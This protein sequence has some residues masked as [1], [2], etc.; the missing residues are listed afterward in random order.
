MHVED[1]RNNKKG[2]KVVK[3]LT[4]KK[5]VRNLLLYCF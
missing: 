3:K 4:L 5:V 1:Y 2:I